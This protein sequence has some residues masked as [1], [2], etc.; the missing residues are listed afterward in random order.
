MPG[1]RQPTAIYRRSS[2]RGW[3]PWWSASASSRRSLNRFRQPS[4][5]ARRD[6]A[7]PRTR[8]ATPGA[9]RRS[10]TPEPAA[11]CAPPVSANQLIELEV[12]SLRFTILS[13]LNEEHHEKRHDRGASVD[14]ELP[15]VREVKERTCGGPDG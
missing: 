14:D 12:H 7:S 11:S 5:L 3:A 15:G 1:S 8:A 4:S 2:F 13:V 10:W 9:D 6:P